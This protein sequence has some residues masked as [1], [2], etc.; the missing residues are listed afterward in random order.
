MIQP[1]SEMDKFKQQLRDSL[2][3]E[4]CHSR[5]IKMS[6]HENVYICGDRDEMVYFIES[7][8]IKLLMLSPEGKECLLAIYTSGDIFGEL[9][10]SGSGARME[11]ATAM[12]E[13]DLNLIPRYK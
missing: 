13:T 6:K 4:N 12:E 2:S 5:I 1:P 9:C 8:H 7:G 10:L 3:R 11:T